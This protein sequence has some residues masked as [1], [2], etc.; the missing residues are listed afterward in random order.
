MEKSLFKK[1][2]IFTLI[3]FFSCQNKEHNSEKIVDANYEMIDSNIS[4][5]VF[6]QKLVKF[7]GKHFKVLD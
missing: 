3:V 7:Y 2:I 1:T 4:Y 6:L 5:P